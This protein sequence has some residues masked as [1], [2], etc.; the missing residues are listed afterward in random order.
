[1]EIEKRI[2]SNAAFAMV[3]R[4]WSAH[5]TATIEI[6]WFYDNGL[7]VLH[8]NREYGKKDT[9]RFSKRLMPGDYFG[10]NNPKLKA[11]RVIC[12]SPWSEADILA[13]PAIGK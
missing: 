5:R 13:V 4:C 12:V 2:R 11:G 7:S 1:M 10:E 6:L 8:A 9:T 3:C